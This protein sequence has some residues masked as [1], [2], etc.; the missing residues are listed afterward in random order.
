MAP[1]QPCF[2]VPVTMRTNFYVNKNENLFRLAGSM[3]TFNFLHAQLSSVSA[4]GCAFQRG[5]SIGNLS[6][7]CPSTRKSPKAGFSHCHLFLFTSS[8]SSESF[9][10]QSSVFSNAK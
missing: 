8:L 5:S 7:G 1:K 6:L 9:Y 2:K 4:S 10:L 3:D